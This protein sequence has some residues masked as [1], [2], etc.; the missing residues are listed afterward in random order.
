VPEALYGRAPAKVNLVFEVLGRRSDGYHEIDT[1]L[2]ELELAD[3]VAIEP[4][5]ATSVEISGPFAEGTPTD[6]RNLALRAYCLAAERANFRGRARI[7][8][9]KEIPAAGGLGGGASDAACVLRLISA[10]LPALT[11]ADLLEIANSI[12]SDEAFFLTGG[13]ARALGRGEAVEVLP[14][15]PV[16]DVVLFIPRET[17]DQ[18]TRR[19][20]EALGQTA[21]DSGAVAKRFADA[22]PVMLRSADV[23]NAFERVAFELFPWLAVLWEDLETRIREPI[24][25][26]G[27]GPAL[28]WIGAA[29]E[30][31]AIAQRANGSECTVIHTRTAAPR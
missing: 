30:G 9:R 18:K 25:L 28:F 26:A 6:E 21:F 12:G 20:F 27:A 31:A 22:A 19:M 23:F 8:L 5:D 1:V 2:Q 13:T 29:G 4:A 14:P 16:H 17:I 3:A 10:W 7:R 11:P 15:L 24:R